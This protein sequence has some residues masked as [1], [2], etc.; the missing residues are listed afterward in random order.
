LSLDWGRRL[1]KCVQTGLGII[2]SRFRSRIE[3][4][5]LLRFPKTPV[6]LRSTISCKWSIV[7]R[8]QQGRKKARTEAHAYPQK[9]YYIPEPPHTKLGGEIA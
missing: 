8:C 7:A 9:L 1:T 5:E 2:G 3:Q 4:G 6:C